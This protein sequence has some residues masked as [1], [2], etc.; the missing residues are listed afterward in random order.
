MTKKQD[1]QK[2]CYFS[3]CLPIQE[4]GSDT[5]AL[6][7]HV[8]GTFNEVRA[9][10]VLSISYDKPYIE[11]SNPSLSVVF[12]TSDKEIAKKYGDKGEK[13]TIHC[14]KNIGLH[15]IFSLMEERLRDESISLDDV[16]SID[17]QDTF[18]GTKDVYELTIYLARD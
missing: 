9:S 4:E 12:R 18:D 8:A 15:K 3:Q 7:R 14:D 10:E 17:F 2:I 16:L 11:N 13:I 5:A 1:D 6:L